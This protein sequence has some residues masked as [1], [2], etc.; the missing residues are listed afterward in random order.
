MDSME[1]FENEHEVHRKRN[2]IATI[3]TLLVLGFLWVFVWRVLF[4]T[5]LIRSG[6]VDFSQWSFL[7]NYSASATLASIPLKEGTFEVSTT[8]DPSLGSV[9]APLMI[10]EFA[11]FQCPFSKQESSI[12]R[13]LAAKYPDKIHVIFRDFPLSDIHPLA[14]TAAEAA[15]CAHEQG[16]FWEYHDRLFQNQSLLSSSSFVQ[17][18]RELNLDVSA[19]ETCVA[20][21]RMGEE[22]LADYAAGVEAGVRGT[23]TFFINGNRIAGAIPKDVLEEMIVTVTGVQ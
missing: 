6:G 20:S 11:D 3:V 23:P 17:F 2:W 1:V 16:K 9:N 13:E 21:D 14:Q 5:D 19:F 18:A 7:S 8:D 15:A 4:F 22:V 10:V 12:V